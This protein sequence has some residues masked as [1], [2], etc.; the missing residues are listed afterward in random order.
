MLARTIQIRG[1]KTIKTTTKTVALSFSFLLNPTHQPIMKVL[2]ENNITIYISYLNLR[3]EL[4]AT[5][6]VVL[7]SRSHIS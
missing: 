4:S 5:V 2:M 6:L 3:V 1:Q 7:I